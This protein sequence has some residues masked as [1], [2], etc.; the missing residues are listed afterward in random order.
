MSFIERLV[1]TPVA[2]RNEPKAPKPV[3]PR[4]HTRPSTQKKPDVRPQVPECPVVQ[5]TN[6]C[7]VSQITPTPVGQ[8]QALPIVH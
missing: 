8:A 1:N 3:A 6:L 2:A 7:P 5:P 4:V